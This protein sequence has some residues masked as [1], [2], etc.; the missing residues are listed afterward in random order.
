MSESKQPSLKSA[1]KKH[2][3]Q[4]TLSE[5][6]LDKLLALQ[7]ESTLEPLA[8]S[9]LDSDLSC[10]PQTKRS[11]MQHTKDSFLSY[12]NFKA[13]VYALASISLFALIITLMPMP[14]SG[15]SI[16]AEIASHHQQPSS[17]NIKS[18]SISEIG[19]QLSKLSFALIHS[20]KLSSD[21]WEFLGGSYCSI[22]GELAAQLKVLNRE[23]NK[24]YTFYQAEYP[25]ELMLDA[26]INSITNEQ[27][28][29]VSIWK[30]EGL[31]LGL[32]HSLN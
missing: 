30:E 15:P 6:K 26:A 22:N 27:G 14:V 10:G 21:V 23:D 19:N 25:D 32:A 5:D 4:K 11:W 9:D 1:L 29:E 17:I 2:Y 13:P 18:S 28:V 7:Q 8:T 24:I 16:L 12:F 20:S 3:Q 31:L